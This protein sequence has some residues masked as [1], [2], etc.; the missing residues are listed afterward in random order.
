MK[1]QMRKYMR[2]VTLLELMIV[3]VIL[4]ILVAVGY[5]NY[6]DF[7]ARAKRTEAKSALLKIAVNQERFYL[8]NEIFTTDMTQLG[9]TTDP[10]TT[11]S[12]AYS[13]DVTS[14]DA[15]DYRATAT[16][17]LG[18]KEAGICREF[19]IDGRGDKTSLDEADCW[20]RRQ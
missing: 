20:T 9:F 18:G 4:G 2:G 5:P 11:D 12:E 7:V 17:L 6:R 3:V 13:V 10:Y 1:I 19:A 16:Y 8:Q 15:T 14:A